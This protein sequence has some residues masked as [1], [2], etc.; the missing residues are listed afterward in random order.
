ML[1]L[2][3]NLYLSGMQ[4]HSILELPQGRFKVD[5]ESPHDLSIPVGNNGQHPRAWWASPLR[6]QPVET[7]DFIGSVEAGAPVNFRDVFIN[8]HGHGTHTESVGHI[9]VGVQSAYLAVPNPWMLAQLISVT[10]LAIGND[11]VVMPDQLKP[12]LV[13]SEQKALVIRTLPNETDKLRRDYS[14]SNPAYLHPDCGAL[15]RDAGIEHLLLDLPSVDRESDEGKLQVH[16]AFW[17][18]PEA[19]R[20]QASITELI[21]V[22][23]EVQDGMYLLHLG[24]LRWENDASP[25]RPVLYPLIPL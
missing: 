22:P 25:S 12:G 9:D 4:L 2:Q 17:N 3:R 5:H 15:L 14:G 21:Y 7:A 10:P 16:H 19:P 13:N 6:F 1:T 23:N 24:L 11:L 8:P 18:H 20:T